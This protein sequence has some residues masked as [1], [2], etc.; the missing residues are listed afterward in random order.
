MQRTFG[1]QTLTGSAQPL[2]GDAMTAAMVLPLHHNVGTITVADSSKYQAGDRIL[3]DPGAADQDI[4]LVQAKPTGTTLSVVSEGDAPLHPH[5]NGTVMALSIPVADV[6]V[7]ANFGTTNPQYLGQD[8]TVTSAGAGK[9]VYVV[10][11]NTPYRAT[12]A[13]GWNTVRTSDFWIAGTAADKFVASA[14]QI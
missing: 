9:V 10:T 1:L 4:V 11:V 5:A 14:N 2:F 7:Q 3:L 8:N 6:V 13:A 12:Y